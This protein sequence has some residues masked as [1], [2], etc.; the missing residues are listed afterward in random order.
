MRSRWVS[1]GLIVSAQIAG[2]A[3]PQDKPVPLAL[4]PSSKQ[5]LLSQCWQSAAEGHKRERNGSFHSL[6]FYYGLHRDALRRHCSAYA[7]EEQAGAWD[8]IRKRFPATNDSQSFLLSCLNASEIAVHKSYDHQHFAR[9][10]DLC[11]QMS[12]DLRRAL[13][14]S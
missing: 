4:A 11:R 6:A 5:A 12:A 9:H 1:V 13:P 10:R 14:S 7:D 2:C 8:K 3:H